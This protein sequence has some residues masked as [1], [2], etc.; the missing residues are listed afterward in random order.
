MVVSEREF[1]EQM[2][3][4]YTNGY[5]VV[6]LSDVGLFV[7]G[8]KELP[9][10]SVVITIDDGYKSYMD[11]AYPIL[12]E[13][14]FPST[15]FVYP[16]FIGAGIALKW[17]DVKKLNE[18]P[19]VDIQS[20]SRT[21]DSLSRRPGGEVDTAYMKR[22]S[23]EVVEAEKIIS[24]RSGNVINQF[25]YPYGNTSLT[26]VEMLKEN[27]YDLAVTVERGSNPAFSAPFL[28]NRDMIYG[29]DDLDVFK[30]RL[31][32]YAKMDLK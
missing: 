20:H 8:K 26:L 10:K 2:Q 32:T 23:S 27:E 7:R 18:D 30:R 24:K 25:A 17:A 13:Y 3:Y 28:L 11:I 6:T 31:E 14:G 5:T 12:R 22:L 29:G 16:E 15:M 19:L 1:R 9:E 21:H 4:L